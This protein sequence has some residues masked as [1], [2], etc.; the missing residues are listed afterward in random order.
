MGKETV[1]RGTAR[2]GNAD[3]DVR[4]VGFERVGHTAQRAAGADCADEAVQLAVGLLPDFLCRGLGVEV[5]VGGIVELVG[6][7]GTVRF[8]GIHLLGQ[9]TGIAGV[10]IGVGIGDGIDLDQLGAEQADRILLFLG[11]GAWHHD[12]NAIA[13]RAAHHGQA[14]PGIAGRAFHD[15]AARFQR[16]ILFRGAYDAQ[17]GTVLD[18]SARIEKLCL[19]EDFTPGLLGRLFEADQGGVA[20]EVDDR[21]RCRHDFAPGCTGLSVYVVQ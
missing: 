14:D 8:A 16:A 5:A 10:M 20:D 12:D 4:I 11:L 13:Q 6:P 1:E 19:A 2:I 7:D 15:R 3:L 9:H 18:R 21:G 17:C